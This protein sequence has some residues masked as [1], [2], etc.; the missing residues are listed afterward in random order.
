MD[1]LKK[2]LNW[3]KE[4]KKK[5]ITGVVGLAGFVGYAIEP[6]IV[7]HALSLA[8]FLVETFGA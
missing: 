8:L 2:A 3:V 6:E 1:Y 4:N 7:D 5:T